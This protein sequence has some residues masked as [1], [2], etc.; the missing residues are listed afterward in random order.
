MPQALTELPAEQA[1]PPAL[2][3]PAH[4]EL[5]SQRQAPPTQRRPAPHGALAPQ[6]Q[7]PP[8]Q[9]SDFTIGPMPHGPL[10][11]QAQAPEEQ[12]SE[13]GPDRLQLPHALPAEPQ[14]V[15]VVE[16]GG[17]HEVPPP[18][19]QP[20]QPLAALHT[21]APPWQMSPAPQGALG[22][23]RHSLPAAKQV[24]A[25][26]NPGLQLPHALPLNPH[27]PGVNAGGATQV[28]PL[29]H[30]GQPLRESQMHTPP[31]QR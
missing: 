19:Q 3:Q 16:A 9:L 23:Q 12:V 15:A 11:P 10:A 8:E 17:V 2:Q 20:V 4:P 1:V 6:R 13:K 22:P 24:S 18:A 21:H 28:L 5:V 14:A 29:Q 26:T 31:L 27:W 7:V 30:P 25:F